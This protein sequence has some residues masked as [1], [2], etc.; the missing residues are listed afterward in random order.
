MGLEDGRGDNRGSVFYSLPALGNGGSFAHQTSSLHAERGGDL[1]V[2]EF[3]SVLDTSFGDSHVH[4]RAVFGVDGR[5]VHEDFD[6]C[7]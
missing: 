3:I 7:T 2:N 1:D 4:S 6:V 5:M